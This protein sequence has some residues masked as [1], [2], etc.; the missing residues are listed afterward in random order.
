[1]N[2]PGKPLQLVLTREFRRENPSSTAR[3]QVQLVYGQKT[4]QLKLKFSWSSESSTVVEKAQ[5]Q[6]K[7][8]NSVEVQLS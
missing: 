1:L 7:K 5:L 2:C 8:F 4:S 6:L 3:R